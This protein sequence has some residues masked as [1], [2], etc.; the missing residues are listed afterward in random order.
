LPDIK[1]GNSQ[2]AQELSNAKDYPS[3]VKAA[4]MEMYKQVGDLVIDAD[5]LAKRGLL[6]RHLV[7]PERIADTELVLSFLTKDISLNTYLNIMDQYRPAFKAQQHPPLD[8]AIQHDEFKAA[9]KLAHDNGF[10]RIYSIIG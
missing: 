4:I 1:Y 9:V 2:I 6:I 8:R 7:L 3:I 5:G 10:Q